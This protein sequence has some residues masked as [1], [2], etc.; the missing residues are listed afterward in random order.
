[1]GLAAVVTAATL[2][3]R[4]STSRAWPWF[5]W[6]AA[7]LARLPLV[8][9]APPFSGDIYRYVWDAQVW[10]SGINPFR[11][12]PCDPHLFFLRT[13]AIYPHINYPGIPTIY[14]LV[15]QCFFLLAGWIAPGVTG[16]KALLAASDMA[17]V[18]LVIR[19]LRRRGLP[20]VWALL[21]A[22]HPLSLTET[23]A[24]GHADVVGAS[25][26]ALGLASVGERPV[27]GAFALAGAALAK[28]N[29]LV[30]LAVVRL[31]A[32]AWAALA[33][34]VLLGAAAFLRPDV[35]PFISLGQYLVRWR[36]NDGLF[37]GI[38]QLTPGLGSAKVV[39]G[40]LLAGWIYLVA[41]RERDPLLAAR[42]ALGALL[43]LSPAIH[44]WYPLWILPLVALAPEPGWLW[45]LS[46]IPLAYGPWP[47]RLA[48]SQAELGL[49]LKAVEFGPALAWWSW[50]AWRRNRAVR[51]RVPTGASK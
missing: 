41:R 17:L 14:P 15:D 6:G 37:W 44:P 13:P 28:W 51:G 11:Y 18:F 29:A 49:A 5:F 1:M 32:R 7:A 48:D 47:N 2:A 50:A 36:W 16:L 9:H 23:S 22:F 31:P 30:V 46:A 33:A 27:R 38:R 24:N 43:L 8:F 20:Q 35:N 19:E 21:A 45:L 34:S 3:G 42:S 25:L 10:R 26:L 40:A 4:S 12:A 39:A